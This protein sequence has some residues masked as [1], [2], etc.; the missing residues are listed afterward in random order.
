MVRGLFLSQ[1]R[2]KTGGKGDQLMTPLNS[3]VM[4]GIPLAQGGADQNCT[5]RSWNQ[6]TCFRQYYRRDISWRHLEQQH[7]SFGRKKRHT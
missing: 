2:G 5:I 6:I 1:H 4:T 3:G 7:F